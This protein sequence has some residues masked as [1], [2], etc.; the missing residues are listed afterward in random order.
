MKKIAKLMRDR[1][2]FGRC[3]VP[4]H[5]DKCGLNCEIQQPQG[6]WLDRRETR[7]EVNMELEADVEVD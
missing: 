3:P 2:K 7:Q 1:K 6:R 4:G 5:G